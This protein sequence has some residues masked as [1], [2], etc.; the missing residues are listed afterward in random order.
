V[1]GMRPCRLEAGQVIT[2]EPGLYYPWLGGIRV[3]DV[4]VVT[5]K[6]CRRLSRFPVFLEIP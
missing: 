1:L 2:V 6:G 4:I 3:E 5:R